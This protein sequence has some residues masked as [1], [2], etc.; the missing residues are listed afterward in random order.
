MIA[1]K[2]YCYLFLLVSLMF[3][4]QKSTKTTLLPLAKG[5]KGELILIMDSGKWAGKLGQ[6]IKGIFGQVQFGLPQPESLYKVTYIKPSAFSGL[7]KRHKNILLVIT[8][9]SDS[10]DTHKMQ[11]YFTK[12]SI[13]KIRQDT[14]AFMVSQQNQYARGQEI[15]Y[16]FGRNEDILIENLKKNKERVQQHFNKI[17]KKRLIKAIKRN[18]DKNLSEKLKTIHQIDIKIPKGFK[19]AK[20]TDDFIWLRHPEVSFDKNLIIAHQPYRSKEQFKPAYIIEWRDKLTKKH[21]YGNPKNKDSY[22][23]TETL[24]PPE[25]KA[26]DFKSKYSLETRGLWR[27]K[28]ISMGGPFISY[29]FY[30]EKNKKLYYIEGFVYA[31]GVKKRELVRELETI[32]WT[33]EI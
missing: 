12:E 25:S 24:V 16:L 26:I 7:L 11:S 31:P 2:N 23:L 4:C 10:Y 3:S 13:K 17:E 29:I 8:L 21:I 5:E 30:S 18:T 6:T 1:I 22:V 15:M 32:L 19:T 14:A 28:N 9:D 33:L 27:T 20:S